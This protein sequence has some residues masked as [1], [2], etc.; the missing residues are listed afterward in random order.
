V[1]PP[2]THQDP[3]QARAGRGTRATQPSRRRHHHPA[4]PGWRITTQVTEITGADADQRRTEIATAVRDLLAW[5][6]TSHGPPPCDAQPS[7]VPT[8]P[9]R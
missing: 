6:A 5:A 9:N 2:P 7:P 8:D 1:S 3:P 4:P